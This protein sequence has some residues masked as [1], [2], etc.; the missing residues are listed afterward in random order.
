[1]KFTKK[2]LALTAAALALCMALSSCSSQRE[3]TGVA[4]EKNMKISSAADLEGKAVAV[5]LRSAEDKFIT[6]NGL[7]KY[8][9]RYSDME[10]A[11]QDLIDKKVAAVVVDSNY[12]QRLY[13]KFS[14]DD[15][16]LKI[17]KKSIGT[18]E[19]RF[20]LKKS[21]AKLAE[22]LNSGI[23]ALKE[24][25][26]YDALIKSELVSGKSYEISKDAE[27]ELKKT[28][29]LVT[30]PSFAPFTYKNKD[31]VRGLFASMADAVA[32]NCGAKLNL[33]TVEPVADIDNVSETVKSAEKNAFCVTTEAAKDDQADF[34][35]TDSFYTSSLVM[36]IR[37]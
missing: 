31:N 27:K 17:V 14:K 6:D 11:L 18:V 22:K 20:K 12:A 4:D 37:G 28:L 8:P 7:T 30:E 34:V 15:V 26:E 21:D 35:T 10:K 23:A 16:K 9:K 1:M 3:D 25:E 19:Y 5:Q 13:E 2:I 33:N 36:I 24:S 32:Y 29:T